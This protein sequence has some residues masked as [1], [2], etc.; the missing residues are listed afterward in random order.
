MLVSASLTLDLLLMNS[1][2]CLFIIKPINNTNMM[3]IILILVGVLLC[4]LLSLVGILLCS[5][6]AVLY[7][8]F[9]LD[10]VSCEGIF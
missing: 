4:N 7:T 6:F 3:L 2:V 5:K 8:I 10:F 1:F 9:I